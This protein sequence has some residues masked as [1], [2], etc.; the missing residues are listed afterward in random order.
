MLPLSLKEHFSDGKN[1]NVISW[2]EE[3][4]GK[5]KRN[6]LQFLLQ[7]FSVADLSIRTAS[8]LMEQLELYIRIDLAKLPSRSTITGLKQTPF[9]HKEELLRTFNLQEIKHIYLNPHHYHY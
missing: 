2:M 6:Q 5:D 8:Q 7:I 4:A 3:I 9:Y 1:E